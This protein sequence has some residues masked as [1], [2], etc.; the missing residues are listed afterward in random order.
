[1]LPLKTACNCDICGFIFSG[2]ALYNNLHILI[3]GSGKAMPEEIKRTPTINVVIQNFSVLERLDNVAEMY[4]RDR[5]TIINQV[6][7]NFVENVEQ[8][9]GILE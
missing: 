1:S 3:R 7:K 4:E 2:R 5:N 8:Y 9:K 6:L